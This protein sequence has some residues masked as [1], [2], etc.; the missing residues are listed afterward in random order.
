MNITE[1][2]YTKPTKFPLLKTA[3]DKWEIRDRRTGQSRH[4]EG[5]RRGAERFAHET[6][7]ELDEGYRNHVEAH[8]ESQRRE[9]LSKQNAEVRDGGGAA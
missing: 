3:R 1:S 6:R 2:E 8:R 4:F 5:G 7:M 9:N